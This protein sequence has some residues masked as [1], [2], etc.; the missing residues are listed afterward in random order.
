MRPVAPLYEGELAEPAG[1][2]DEEYDSGHDSAE[3]TQEAGDRHFC[4]GWLEVRRQG[5]LGKEHRNVT[6]GKKKECDGPRYACRGGSSR[7]Y[8][9][10]QKKARNT[11][12][13]S[14]IINLCLQP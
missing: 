8:W 12:L 5:S 6:Q 1:D 13:S 7:N 11:F 9:P 14:L 4:A 10:L 3:D 2:E